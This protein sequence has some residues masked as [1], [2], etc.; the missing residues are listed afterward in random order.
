MLTRH[1]IWSEEKKADT[2]I[3]PFVDL[4]IPQNLSS[5]WT[6]YIYHES[7]LPFSKWGHFCASHDYLTYSLG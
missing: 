3:I 2:L 4:P 6:W 5:L 1:W 7:S